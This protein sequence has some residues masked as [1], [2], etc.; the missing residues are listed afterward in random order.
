MGVVNL[1]SL[2][3][4]IASE[5]SNTNWPSIEIIKQPTDK[6]TINK[7]YLVLDKPKTNKK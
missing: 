1:T 2:L 6:S 3:L 4:T 7:I 5:S